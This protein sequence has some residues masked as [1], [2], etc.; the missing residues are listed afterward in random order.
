[1]VQSLQAKSWIE[2]IHWTEN[3]AILGFDDDWNE[4]G[5]YMDDCNITVILYSME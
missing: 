2:W 4:C 3:E 5:K 1:M